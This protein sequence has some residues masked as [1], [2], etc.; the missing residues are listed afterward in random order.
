MKISVVIPA[1]NE[2]KYIA[3]TLDAVLAQDYPDF[4]VIVVNNNSS[5]N[6]AQVIA[7]YE[8]DARIRIVNEAQQGL[9]FARNAGLAAAT[10]EVLA[11][12]DA[13]CIPSTHWLSDAAAYFNDAK[14]VGVTGPY[15]YYDASPYFRMFTKLSQ[16]VSFGVISWY[17][18]REKKGALLIGG[19]AFIKIA[20][21]KKVGGYNTTLQFY[22]EDTDTASRIAPYGKVLFVPSLSI[23]T[24]ARRFA[25]QGFFTIQ[26]KYNQAFFALMR[27]KQ[28][29]HEHS[30]ETIHP[31]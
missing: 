14:V 7:A 2:E 31:R 24:S 15:E 1:Y 22:A 20:V 26:K 3:T 4:E 10:G 28:F 9:L 12:L 21:L 19:N 11:Q 5:D 6:T 18:Q 17:V 13:D 30:S 16:Q 8:H 23:K 25:T 29:S 27:G